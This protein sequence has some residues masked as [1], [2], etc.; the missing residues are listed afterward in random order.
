[1]ALI[2][3]LMAKTL[4]VLKSTKVLVVLEEGTLDLRLK[5][6]GANWEEG[7]GQRGRHRRRG[8]HGGDHDVSSNVA[9]SDD[10]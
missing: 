6:V 4:K 8:K 1:M 2:V 10:E 9:G 3:L 7:R 5:A